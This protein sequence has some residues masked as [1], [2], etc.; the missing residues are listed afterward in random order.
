MAKAL[1]WANT[2][3]LANLFRH[4]RR[5]E[6]DISGEQTEMHRG[7]AMVQVEEFETDCERRQFEFPLVRLITC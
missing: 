3:E 4:C 2:A 5:D 7:G 1:V 6:L